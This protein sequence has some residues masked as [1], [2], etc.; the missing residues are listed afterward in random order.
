MTWLQHGGGGGVKKT[1]L[2]FGGRKSSNPELAAG[3]NK[4]HELMSNA[5]IGIS[6][7]I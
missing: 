6:I 5:R 7:H 4:A 3:Q 1:A 2:R